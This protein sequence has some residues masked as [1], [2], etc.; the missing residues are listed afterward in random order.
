MS[1]NQLSCTGTILLGPSSASEG[2]VPAGSTSIPFQTN[3]NPKNAA[4]C[5]GDQVI[6]VSSPGSYVALPGVAASNSN[7]TQGTFLFIRTTNLMMVRT[8]TYNVSGNVVAVEPVNGTKIVEY[9]PGAYL[10]LVEVEGSGTVEYL[11]AGP[12]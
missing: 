11:V 9:D 8:T 7:V 5:T 3:P 4:A 10:V 2:G 12:A 1:T 6:S